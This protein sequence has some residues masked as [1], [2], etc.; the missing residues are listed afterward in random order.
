LIPDG[1]LPGFNLKN[2]ADRGFAFDFGSTGKLDHLVFYRPGEILI[3]GKQDSGEFRIVYR[4]SSNQEIGGYRL[5]GAA[6]RVFAFDGDGNGHMD[7]LV[8]YRP[9]AGKISNMK[10]STFNYQATFTPVYTSE[11]KGIGGYD[12]GKEADQGMAFDCDAT[13]HVEYLVFYRPGRGAIYIFKKND[14]GTF[15]QPVYR[16][17]EGDNPGNALAIMT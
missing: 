4:S 16:R 10:R 6:D 8:L 11:T 15:D 1:G 5:Q 9:G 12:L 14:T 13:G 17:N 7:H 3:W 2:A